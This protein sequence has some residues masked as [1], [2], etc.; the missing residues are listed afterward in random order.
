MSRNHFV[1]MAQSFS[2]IADVSARREAAL[3]FAEV[4]SSMNSRFNYSRFM[5][6]CGL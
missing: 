4:A 5:E 6:A 2:L 3:A 1:A